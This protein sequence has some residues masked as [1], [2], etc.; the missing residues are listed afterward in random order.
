LAKLERKVELHIFFS[1]HCV[2]S[3]RDNEIES[4]HNTGRP[5]RHRNTD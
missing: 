2:N 5:S 4:T 1:G 3:K